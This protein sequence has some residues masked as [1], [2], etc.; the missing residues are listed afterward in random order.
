MGEMVG[1]KRFAARV[2]LCKN[3]GIN[4]IYNFVLC[5]YRCIFLSDQLIL[6]NRGQFK[7]GRIFI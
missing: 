1:I 7:F 2:G 6:N 3:L 5:G 4:K